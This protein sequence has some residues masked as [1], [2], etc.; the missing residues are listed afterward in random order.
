[1]KSTVAF[2]VTLIASAQ[3]FSSSFVGSSVST[4]ATNGD[5]VT[6]E[7]IRK[8]FAHPDACF[9][10]LCHLVTD[11][12]HNLFYTTFVVSGLVNFSFRHEQRT[13][14]PTQGKGTKCQ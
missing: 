6:M 9:E 8:Y 4:S 13:M 10:D 1:M 5:R 2:L 14:A 11:M 7:Y 3:A 12:S